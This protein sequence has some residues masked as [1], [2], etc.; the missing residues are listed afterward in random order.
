MYIILDT[1]IFFKDWLFRKNLSQAFVDY[2]RKTCAQVILSKIIIEEVRA[3]YRKELESK[4][5]EYERACRELNQ[6]R[7][8][9]SESPF[10]ICERDCGL[11]I[12]PI[13]FVVI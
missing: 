5:S 9:S 8:E 4:V 7:A 2:V 10:A 12:P 3:N 6:L 11:S 1:N 13:N